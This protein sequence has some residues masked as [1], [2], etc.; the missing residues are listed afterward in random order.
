MSKWMKL[1]KF[2][3]EEIAGIS[4][5]VI[6]LL[7][8]ILYKLYITMGEATP[9]PTSNCWHRCQRRQWNWHRQWPVE[10]ETIEP[11]TQEELA[12]GWP[13]NETDNW[14][15]VIEEYNLINFKTWGPQFHIWQEAEAAERAAADKAKHATDIVNGI[16]EWEYKVHSLLLYTLTTKVGTQT[17]TPES[18]LELMWEKENHF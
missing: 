5:A 18:L 14:D 8:A 1:G 2:T 17:E 9:P 13:T 16:I 4:L 12:A 3:T 6:L 15:D 11:W 10:E 7:V